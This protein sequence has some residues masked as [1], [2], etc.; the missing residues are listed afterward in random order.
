VQARVT[1]IHSIQLFHGKRLPVG[2]KTREPHLLNMGLNGD[3]E[4]VL[5]VKQYVIDHPGSPSAVRRPRVFR[6]GDTFIVLLG[7][8]VQH[9]IVGLGNTIENALRAFDM[10]YYN[11]L[12]PPEARIVPA[13]AR[14]N[15]RS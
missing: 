2:M 5:Q 10:Q 9:G 12:R 13:K 7:R 3:G 1:E 14:V 4:A 15:C 6:Q 8:D 11:A